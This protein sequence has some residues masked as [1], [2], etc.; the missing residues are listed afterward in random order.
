MSRPVKNIETTSKTEAEKEL[1]NKIKTLKLEI[2]QLKAIQSAMPDPYYVRDMDYNVIF[3]PDAIAKLTGYSAIEAKKTKCYNMFKACVC[4]PGSDCPTQHCIQVKQFLKDV[5]VDVYHKSGATVHTLVSNAGVYDDDGNPIGAV[6]IVKDNTVIH[7]SMDEIGKIIK[8]VEA[9]SAELTHALE[10]IGVVTNS[11]NEKATT[12][13]K[14]IKTGVL[15]GQSV[16]E[17]TE[18]SS[19]YAGSIQSNMKTINDSMKISVEKINMLKDKLEAIVQFVKI[20]QEISAK[21]NLLAIN[22][23]IE[24][25][26][27]GES[28]KGFKVVADGIRELSKNSSESATQINKTIQEIT[29]LVKETTGSLGVTDKD[30]AKG[31]TGIGELLN[32]VREIDHETKVLLDTLNVVQDMAVSSGQLSVEQNASIAMASKVS[33]ALTAISEKLDHEFEMVYKAIQH[34]DMG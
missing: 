33:S 30:I 26:H 18:H 19:Q 32:R 22:A 12:T 5:A 4:P 29:G 21:T 3:W 16:Y 1:Q 13:V 17:K 6:E 9:Q 7:A 31:T 15:A 24:A 28:G 14:I 11:V 25:A 8:D 34:Q 27:A 20:I 23:S 2:A 10:N